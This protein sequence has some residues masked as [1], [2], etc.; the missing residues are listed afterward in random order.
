MPQWSLHGRVPTRP[1]RV[2][3]VAP[4]NIGRPTIGPSTSM[5]ASGEHDETTTQPSIRTARRLAGVPSYS[6]RALAD[7]CARACTRFALGAHRR[8]QRLS[9]P[10]GH[11]VTADFPDACPSKHKRRREASSYRAV[12]NWGTILPLS[13]Q[14]SVQKALRARCWIAAD[15]C[16]WSLSEPSFETTSKPALTSC[17]AKQSLGRLRAQSHQPESTARLVSPPVRQKLLQQGRV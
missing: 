2:S 6:R 13:E 12:Q 5:M 10:S 11:L 15:V 1:V 16:S 9:K 8:P 7:R 4:E 14:R 3:N 17:L